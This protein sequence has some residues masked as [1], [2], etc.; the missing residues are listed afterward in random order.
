MN[1]NEFTGIFES[2]YRLALPLA[3]I[4]GTRLI[5]AG[6]LYQSLIA[7]GYK[8]QFMNVY[9]KA[10][11]NWLYLFSAWDTGYYVYMAIGWYPAT[12]NPVWAF[13]PLYPAVIRTLLPSGIDPLLSAWLIATIFGFASIVAFQKVTEL[14]FSA[15]R[16]ALST[17]LYF[18]FPPVLLFS[19]VNYSEP[20]FLLFSVGAWF[21]AKKSKFLH[22]NVMAAFCSLARQNGLLLLVPLALQSIKSRSKSGLVYLLIPIM[23]SVGW[24]IYGYLATGIPFVNRVAL[25]TY[26]RIDPTSSSIL[27]ALVRIANGDLDGIHVILSN[28]RIIAEGSLF[29]AIIILLGYRAY[30]IEQALGIYVLFSTCI[31]IIY[32]FLTS[33]FSFARYFSFLFPIGLPLYSRRKWLVACAIV[34]FLALEYFLWNAYL[35]DNFG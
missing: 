12:L 21:F 33:P 32:G 7:T 16:A 24:L 17:V 18:L 8:L 31:I 9:G 30:K 35:T 13:S 11:Y 29:V 23:A 28:A 19:G 20:L 15:R 14:Y 25:T 10:P 4:L 5:L 2:K 22:A 3:V 34:L 6:F 27:E 26:W 1:T